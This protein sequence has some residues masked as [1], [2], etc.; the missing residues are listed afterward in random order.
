[1]TNEIAGKA[2]PDSTLN[3]LMHVCIACMIKNLFTL[4]NTCFNVG[5]L[6]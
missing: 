5:T 3:H 4:F 6:G 1:M 2:S